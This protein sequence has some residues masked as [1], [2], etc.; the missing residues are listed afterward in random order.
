MQLFPGYAGLGRDIHV[1]CVDFDDPVKAAEI[2]NADA[3][4]VRGISVGVGHAGSARVQ[5]D[6]VAVTGGGCAAE[7]FDR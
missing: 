2:D 4:A 1:P 5:R 3:G 6:T 7:V